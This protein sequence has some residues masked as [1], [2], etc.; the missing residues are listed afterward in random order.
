MPGQPRKCWTSSWSNWLHGTCDI[1]LPCLCLRIEVCMIE[2]LSLTSLQHKRQTTNLSTTGAQ[3]D[4]R[5]E[6]DTN[7][8]CVEIAFSQLLCC[9]VLRLLCWQNLM[10]KQISWVFISVSTLFTQVKTHPHKH[11]TKAKHFLTLKLHLCGVIPICC[12]RLC[13]SIEIFV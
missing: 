12:H 6:S 8:R 3:I 4:F 11:A 9:D 10:P 13:L 7:M 1:L 2:N 5:Y